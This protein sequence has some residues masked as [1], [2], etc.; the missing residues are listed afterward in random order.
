MQTRPGDAPDAGALRIAVAED[1]ALIRLDLVEALREAGY[2]VVGEA[3]DGRTAL[4]AESPSMPPRTASATGP[5]DQIHPV[6]TR[7]PSKSCGVKRDRDNESA[8]GTLAG[9]AQEESVDVAVILF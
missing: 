8:G 1:E 6:P 2:D 5:P 3:S 7:R 9:Q 4:D